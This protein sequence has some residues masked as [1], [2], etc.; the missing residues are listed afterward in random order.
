MFWWTV[1]TFFAGV[2]GAN[3]A[4]IFVLAANAELT[5][6]IPFTIV[7]VGQSAGSFLLIWMFSRRAGSGSLQADVGLTLNP[8]DWWG[9]S[10]V[11]ASRYLWRSPRIPSSG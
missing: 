4:G 7:F 5:D 6:P 1:G 11:W 8:S 9:S 3:M 10:P 2:L